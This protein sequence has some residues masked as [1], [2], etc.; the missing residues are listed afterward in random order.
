MSPFQSECNGFGGQALGTCALGRYIIFEPNIMLGKTIIRFRD[1]LCHELQH[2]W[3]NYHQ[4]YHLHQVYLTDLV[5]CSLLWEWNYEV[6]RNPG[7][8]ST[9][10]SAGTC[11]WRI[12]KC[13]DDI[14]QIRLDF[15]TMEIADP[16]GGRES[17]K[18]EVEIFYISVATDGLVGR[19]QTDYFQV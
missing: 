10:S 8:P 2:L 18:L 12:S 11:E 6:S 15:Q 14:C 16:D 9:Y 19:C 3:W 1:L 17:Q 5:I 13:R 7:Y 4:K